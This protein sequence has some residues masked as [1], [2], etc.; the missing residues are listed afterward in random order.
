MP[1]VLARKKYVLLRGVESLTP[2][3][4]M[5]KRKRM[6]VASMTR[7]PRPRGKSTFSDWLVRICGKIQVVKAIL[8]CECGRC[9]H[10]EQSMVGL[11]SKT[12]FGAA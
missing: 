10:A 4:M 11:L 5:K 6:D 12:T 1:S 2:E 7:P 8:C 3:R 9:R